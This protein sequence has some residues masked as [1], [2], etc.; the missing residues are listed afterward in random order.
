VYTGSVVNTTGAAEGTP[1]IVIAPTL[2]QVLV[3]QDPL[4]AAALGYG[5]G[6]QG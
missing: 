4:L 6:D 5:R 3:G 2:R 1:D